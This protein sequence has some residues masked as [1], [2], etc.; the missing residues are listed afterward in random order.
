[1]EVMASLKL[2]EKRGVRYGLSTDVVNMLVEGEPG[3]LGDF[4]IAMDRMFFTPFGWFE[5]A[6]RSGK[7]VWNVDAAGRHVPVSREEG[8]LLARAMHGLNLPVAKALAEVHSLAGRSHLLDI[9]GGSGVMSIGLALKN[10]DLKATVLD[11]PAVCEVARRYIDEAGLSSRITAKDSDFFRDPFPRDAD[12][13]LYCNILHNFSE[14]ECRGL[15]EKSFDSLAAGGEVLVVEY[16]LDE[17]GTSPAFSALFNLFALVVMPQG[18]TRPY[19][20]FR[21]W[22]METGFVKIRRRRLD[23]FSVLIEARTPA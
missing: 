10:P 17:H 12:I 19:G 23:R 6:V 21:R 2:L 1:M 20:V 14:K 13:H 22:M 11:R 16:L 7:A 3:Y 8:Q 9:G 5:E 18:E 15:L 4:F